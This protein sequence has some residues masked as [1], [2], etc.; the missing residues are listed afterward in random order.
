MLSDRGGGIYAWCREA[1]GTKSG[2]VAVYC[3]WS[4]NRV[5]F[6]TGLAF[7]PNFATL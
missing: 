2:F 1:F 6:P 7:I 5:W 4:T 3:V